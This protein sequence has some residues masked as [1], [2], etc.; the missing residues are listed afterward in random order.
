MKTIQDLILLIS[1]LN[2]IYSVAYFLRF[3]KK[4]E[5]LLFKEVKVLNFDMPLFIIHKIESLYFMCT[6]TKVVVK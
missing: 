4:S 3:L 5:E 2:W 1:S 6:V